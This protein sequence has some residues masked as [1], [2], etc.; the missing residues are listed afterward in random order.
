M[1]PIVRMMKRYINMPLKY[2]LPLLFIGALVL[3]ATTGCTTQ[4]TTQSVVNQSADQSGSQQ[5]TTNPI[6]VTVKAAGT[7]MQVGSYYTPQSGY[8]YVLYTATVKNNNAKDLHVNPTYFTLRTTDSKVYDVTTA[9]YDSSVND[10]K[11]VTKT[12]PGDV[13]TGTII[14]EI[15]QSATP[16]SILYDDYSHKVTTNL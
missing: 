13:V 3:S 15:P 7:S 8:K 11:M 2:A 16:K 4:D 10:F 1:N 12:Q 9:M 14:Y 6:S 5:Q